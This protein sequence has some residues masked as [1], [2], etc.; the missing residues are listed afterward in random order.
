MAKSTYSTHE[1]H[2]KPSE[3]LSKLFFWDLLANK[4][5][6]PTIILFKA[7]TFPKAGEEMLSS[8]VC[9]IIV[10]QV[11]GMKTSNRQLTRL[12]PEIIAPITPN[13]YKSADYYSLTMRS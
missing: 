2:R 6:V 11:K 10:S 4:L 12:K 7:I 8:P 13:I 9:L 1:V 5:R 3:G